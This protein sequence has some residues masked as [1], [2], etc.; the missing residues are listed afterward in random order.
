[1]NTIK[2][3][4]WFFLVKRDKGGNKEFLK[5]GSSDTTSFVASDGAQETRTPFKRG[6]NNEI[7]MIQRSNFLTDPNRNFYKFF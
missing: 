6:K 1:L 7:K 5:N 3:F 2:P 4:C